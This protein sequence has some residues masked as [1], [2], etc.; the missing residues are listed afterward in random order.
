[1][2][3]TCGAILTPLLSFAALPDAAIR[4]WTADNGNGTHPNPLV[5]G[6]FEDP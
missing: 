2:L 1:M 6:E 3:L 5:Y 4:H